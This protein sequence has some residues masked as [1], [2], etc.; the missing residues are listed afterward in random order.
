MFHIRYGYFKYQVILFNLFNAL[1]GFQKYINKILAEKLNIL[2]ISYLDD[3][4]IYI[5]LLNQPHIN[6]IC[7]V[8]EQL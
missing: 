3:I 1:T 2:I 8:L 7:Q 4:L 5:E 6:A